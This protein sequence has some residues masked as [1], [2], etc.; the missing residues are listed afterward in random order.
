VGA[1]SRDGRVSKAIDT[2]IAGYRATDTQRNPEWAK[3]VYD[4]EDWIERTYRGEGGSEMLLFVAR[5]YNLK[6]LYHHP[7]LG[8][9]HGEDLS[10]A[11][12]ADMPGST[13]IPVH[14]LRA[15][16]GSGVAV[17]ALLYD[18]QF[19]AKPIALQLTTSIQQL[20]SARKPMTLF[21]AHDP[22]APPGAAVDQLAVMRILTGA[23]E[24]FLSQP[25]N[26]SS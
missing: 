4:S 23:I 17:Y 18:D 26:A 9:L 21:L 7:E 11:V 5:S 14:V 2:Y 13:G 24:S 16:T 3:D 15:N 1:T 22:K 19:V 25:T 8:V 10:R 20:V 6:R 12:T